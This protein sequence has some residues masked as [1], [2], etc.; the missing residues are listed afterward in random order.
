[1][2]SLSNWA[3]AVFASPSGVIVLGALDSTLFFSLPFGIDA[4]VIVL[5]ARMGTLAWL[6]P[7]LATAGSVGGAFLTF[8]MGMKIGEKG[9]EHYIAAKR[10]ARVRSKIH[11]SG[12]VALAVLDLIPPPFPFTLFVLAAGALDVRMPTF[13]ITLALC[14]LF[15]FGIEA[16]L[17]AYYGRSILAWLDSDIVHDIVTGSIAVATVLSAISIFKLIRSARTSGRRAARRAPAS[18]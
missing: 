18:G 9:L 17:A 14:R 8:W 1:M 2:R 3:F 7:F 6:V 12:A 16:L 10:L 5:S 11:S 13:F 15:R 4:V